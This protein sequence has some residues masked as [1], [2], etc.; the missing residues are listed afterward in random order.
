MPDFNCSEKLLPYRAA[1]ENDCCAGTFVV[2]R[3]LTS[4]TPLAVAIVPNISGIS[5]S[6]L[7]LGFPLLLF[8]ATIHCIIVVSNPLCQNQNQ[9]FI[10]LTHVYI[11]VI[12]S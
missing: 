4:A 3:C 9:N 7:C 1:D 6:H 2:K 11:N 10:Y 8:P 12:V 5:F